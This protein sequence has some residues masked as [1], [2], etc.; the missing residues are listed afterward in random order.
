MYKLKRRHK[1]D[2]GKKAG[3]TERLMYGIALIAPIMTI[4]QAMQVWFDH[5]VQGV[6]ITT[7]GAYAAV[8]C[9]W[10]VY[11]T[12]HKERPLVLT[13]CLLIIVDT[14]IVLGVLFNH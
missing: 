4:P 12:I 5:R 6:S 3:G 10:L 13:H 11:A 14:S 1:N 8:S 9:L 2:Q 7:W